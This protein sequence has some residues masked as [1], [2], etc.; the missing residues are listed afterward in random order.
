M[1]A[2]RVLLVEDDLPLADMMTEFL[3]QEGFLVSVCHDGDTACSLIDEYKQSADDFNL[4]ILDLMLP[5]KDGL[6]ICRYLRKH[7]NIPVLMLTAK[8]DDM[9]AAASLQLGVDNYLQKPVR[10]HLLL[11]HIEALMR[12]SYSPQEA[13]Q[14]IRIDP[15]SYSASLKGTPLDLTSGEYQLLTYLVEHA[16]EVIS[17]EKLYQDIRGIPFDGIDRAIDLRISTLRKKLG[18]DQPPYRY[19]KTVRSRGYILAL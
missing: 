19:I 13:V 8:D 17:R 9:I 4:A 2:T 11:A 18:D 5:G 1:T 7:S 16:G 10:P 14:D 12:R 6:E 15:A 3:E